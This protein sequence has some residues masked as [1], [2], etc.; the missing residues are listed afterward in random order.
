M[1]VRRVAVVG[2]GHAGFTACATLRTLG[3]DGELTLIDSDQQVALP[4]SAAQQKGPGRRGD[5]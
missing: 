1:S 4:T 3:W 2:A 5:P